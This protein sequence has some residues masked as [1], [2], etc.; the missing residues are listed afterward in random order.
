MT[1]APAAAGP[2]P[3]PAPIAAA[4]PPASAAAAA[5]G[6]APAGPA[7][8][9]ETC[10]TA[11]EARSLVGFEDKQRTLTE[12]DA[13][14]MIFAARAESFMRA[15][16]KAKKEVKRMGGGSA[17]LGV[18]V[19]VATTTPTP[20]TQ[21]GSGLNFSKNGLIIASGNSSFTVAVDM[22]CPC[23]LG[24]F[25]HTVT[26]KCVKQGG[27][28]YECGFFPAAYQHRVCQDGLT[29]KKVDLIKDNYVS[30]GIYEKKA[31]SRPATCKVCTAEDKCETG[32]E[33]HEA[34]CPKKASVV[35][36]SCSNV[37]ILQKS[38]NA[39]PAAAPAGAPAA[40][41]AAGPVAG[42]AGAPAAA[43]TPITGEACFDEA[44]GSVD[45][46]FEKP[47]GEG[48]DVKL[49]SRVRAKVFMRA[50]SEAREKAAKIG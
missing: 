44:Q 10:L 32:M 6:P 27:F 17:A 15:T 43:G 22:T 37:Q 48:M 50:S 29:C 7:A 8:T 9:M 46:G 47:L 13:F 36:R 42:P 1:V 12:K 20:T 35:G 3:A 40:A 2:A 31:G 5:P 30:H 23:P 34:N 18:P 39:A 45:L 28:G 4:A 19:A 41:P 24:T 14:E 21:P 26:K 38:A 16:A 33:R 49:I 25:F 11:A